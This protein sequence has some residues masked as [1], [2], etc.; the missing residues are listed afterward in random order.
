MDIRT[1]DFKAVAIALVLVVV[2][3][4]AAGS[5]LLWFH[6][7]HRDDVAALRRDPSYRFGLHVDI[8]GIDDHVADRCRQRIVADNPRIA[9]FSTAK[10]VVGC[11]DEWH[12]VNS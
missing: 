4:V 6:H 2:G 12:S 3:V 1:R 7:I 8:R 5:A 11:I 10:A 9:G